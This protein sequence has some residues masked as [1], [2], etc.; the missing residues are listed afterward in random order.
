M[1]W[2]KYGARRTAEAV[3]GTVVR[4]AEAVMRL[5]ARLLAEVA[6]KLGRWLPAETV[7]PLVD[8]APAQPSWLPQ[9]AG[10]P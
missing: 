10:L 4:S 6:Q 3:E 5:V 2:L 1:D 8:W 9:P 7:E